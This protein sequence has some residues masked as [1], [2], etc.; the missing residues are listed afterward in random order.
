MKKK[1]FIIVG[2]HVDYV[3]DWIKDYAI[4]WEKLEGINLQQQLTNL[5]ATRI[6]TWSIS[7]TLF[8]KIS[9]TAKL[10]LKEYWDANANN[11][12]SNQEV[13]FNLFERTN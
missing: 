13:Y 11:L 8:K 12:L 1:L 4:S 3:D 7:P 10:K 6:E 2:Y 9:P 5:L